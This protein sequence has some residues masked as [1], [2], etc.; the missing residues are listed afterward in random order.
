MRILRN[1]FI[2]EFLR[3]FFFSL[4]GITLFLVL[5][6]L[7]KFSD[8][9]IRK[10]VDFFLAA[11]CFIYY[12]PYLLQ[13][14]IPLACLL[15]VLLSVGR[16]SSEN[17]ILAL[18]ISGVSVGRILVLLLILGLIIFLCTVILHDK[19]IPKAHYASYKV[20][21]KIAEENP[22]SLIEPGVFIDEFEGFKL[23]THDVEANTMQKVY[24]YGLGKGS[25]TLIYADRGDFV[26]EDD[27]LKIRL[28]DGFTQ[29]TEM[30][31]RSEFKNNYLH[32]P[33]KKEQ[34][35]KIQKKPKDM[36]IKEIIGKIKP[37]EK[38][39]LSVPVKL[40]AELHRKL[41]ISFS[42]FIFIL[43][44]FGIAGAIR[45]REKSINLG[46]CFGLG[47]IYYLVALLGQT[48]VLKE[49]LPVVLGM[50][51]ANIIFLILGIVFSYKICK[52]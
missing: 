52:S 37:L 21:E 13:Y 17:E 29:S 49:I 44:G 36:G 4:F 51:M 2:K 42:C 3:Y 15:G 1:Y 23:F 7:V 31:Y 45:H 12:I 20:L 43:L 28:Q 50:W 27:I 46:V 14:V 35:A 39:G 5:G 22:L 38:K 41:S 32:L 30:K 26:V 8:L 11:Q 48:L 34:P 6:N 10:G 47:L 33:I 9:I 40:Q 25:S 24:I 19:I 18:K 16:I